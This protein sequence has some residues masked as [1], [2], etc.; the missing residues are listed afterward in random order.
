MFKAAS[1]FM[2]TAGYL[3]AVLSLVSLLRLGFDIGLAAPLNKMLEFYVN[4]LQ[5]SFGWADPY[6]KALLHFIDEHFALNLQLYP[7]WKQLFVPMWLYF[8]TGAKAHWDD[9]RRSL[10]IWIIVFGFILAFIVS[11]ASS[12]MPLNTQ[13]MLPFLF[14]VATMILYS[15]VMTG[16]MTTYPPHKTIRRGVVYSRWRILLYYIIAFPL[17]D[18]FIGIAI[19]LFGNLVRQFAFVSLNLVLLFIYIF[20]LAL[21]NLAVSAWIATFDRA[22]GQPWIHRF[23]DIVAHRQGLLILSTVVGAALFLALNAGL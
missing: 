4:I 8:S 19:L 21:R 1:R 7:H 13:S 16:I 22:E 11:V 9:Q 15:S 6:L 12:S 14:S 18:S 23:Q 17:A 5:L 3:C 10:A 2:R 20:S